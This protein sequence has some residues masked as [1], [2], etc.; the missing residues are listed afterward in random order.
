LSTTLTTP[1]DSST[2]KSITS[3]IPDEDEDELTLGLGSFFPNHSHPN[4]ISAADPHSRTKQTRRGFLVP[5]QRGPRTPSKRD[6]HSGVPTADQSRLN[7]ESSSG[8]AN[9][10]GGIS[11][12]AGSLTETPGGTLRRCGEDGFRCGR[13]FCFSCVSI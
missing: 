9:N 4:N 13:E 1:R 2:K 3:L 5:K 7:G 6:G 8:G 11:S 12:P 10:W